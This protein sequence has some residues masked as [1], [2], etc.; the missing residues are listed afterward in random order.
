MPEDAVF[1]AVIYSRRH[2]AVFHVVPQG[3]DHMAGVIGNGTKV[4]HECLG[5]GIRSSVSGIPRE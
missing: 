1:I 4:L 2:Q 3:V 5:Y